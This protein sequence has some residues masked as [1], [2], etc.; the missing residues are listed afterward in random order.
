MPKFRISEDW[1][2]TKTFSPAEIAERKKLLRVHRLLLSA[3]VGTI[4]GIFPLAFIVVRLHFLVQVGGMAL[5]FALLFLVVHKQAP[6]EKQL[7]VYYDRIFS[8]P[9]TQE[10]RLGRIFVA[11]FVSLITLPVV[12]IILLPA[13]ALSALAPVSAL[14]FCAMIFATMLYGAHLVRKRETTALRN[15]PEKS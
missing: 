6:I 15:W 4:T 2:I 8:K 12:L 5:W 11:E 10:K 3:L 14:S 9:T 13:V 7:N 1:V